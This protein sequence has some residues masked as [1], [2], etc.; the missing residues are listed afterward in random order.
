MEKIVNERL[1][2]QIETRHLLK[3]YQSGRSTTDPALYLEN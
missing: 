2:Y 3:N 1:K